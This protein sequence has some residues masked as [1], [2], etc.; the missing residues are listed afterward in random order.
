MT[1]YQYLTSIL[2]LFWVLYFHLVWEYF[3]FKYNYL[4]M[5]IENIIIN[6]FKNSLNCSF[7][8]IFSVGKT[9]FRD[10]SLERI[11]FGHIFSMLALKRLNLMILHSLTDLIF[12]LY[13]LSNPIIKFFLL[14]IQL[15]K[16]NLKL[17]KINTF[18]STVLLFC[19]ASIFRYPYFIAD[20]LYS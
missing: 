11:R 16:I 10:F 12:L 14:I 2:S 20:I 5:S 6:E 9:H 1:F 4:F 8:E 18:F 3:S 15:I 17:T 7:L 13:F 19:S